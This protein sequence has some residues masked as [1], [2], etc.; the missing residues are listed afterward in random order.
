MDILFENSD[1]LDI[2][3]YKE[4]SKLEASECIHCD[5]KYQCNGGCLVAAEIFTGSMY[6]GDLRCPKLQNAVPTIY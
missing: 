1:K 4:V 2:F 3:R 5:E 6:G